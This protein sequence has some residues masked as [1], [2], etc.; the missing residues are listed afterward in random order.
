[1][2]YIKRIF[3]NSKYDE[4]KELCDQYLSY[5]YDK[6]FWVN[7]IK[8]EGDNFTIIFLG[9]KESNFKWD[10]VKEDLTSF[11]ELLSIKYKIR[12]IIHISLLDPNWK[13]N[14]KAT[15]P[16]SNL[17]LSVDEILKFNTGLRIRFI[18]FTIT[19]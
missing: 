17:Y 3:E 11:I 7:L 8:E 5:L 9:E 2:R 18:E 13:N 6:G 1:M 10:D 12:G 15:S 16:V 19:I 4:I 14:G